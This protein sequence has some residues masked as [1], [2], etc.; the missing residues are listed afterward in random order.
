MI[1]FEKAV[2][3]LKIEMDKPFHAAIND[4]YYTARVMQRA[5]LKNLKEKYTYDIYRH[6]KSKDEEILDFHNSII[7]RI[8]MEYPSK[9]DAMSNKELSG[10]VCP[11]CGKP[12]KRRVK[13]FQM[14]GGNQVAVGKCLIHGNVMATIKFKPA[15]DSRDD[16]FAIER[17]EKIKRR[18]YI[19]LKDK[20]EKM[21]EKKRI[22]REIS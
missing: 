22:I 3:M 10:V 2:D 15:S 8:T 16:V 20:R 4:A 9:R 19:E 7:E 17:V 14:N 5:H 13:W 11:K 21:L 6:P 12:T 18:K 1:P